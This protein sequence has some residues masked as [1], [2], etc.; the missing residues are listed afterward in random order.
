MV[1]GDHPV[2][3]FISSSFFLFSFFSSSLL[4]LVLQHSGMALTLLLFRLSVA[5]HDE[6]CGE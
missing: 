6:S 1:D 3:L 2:I 4:L 5:V